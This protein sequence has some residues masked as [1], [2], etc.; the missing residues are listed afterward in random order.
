M[1]LPT[2]NQDISL[3]MYECVD[4]LTNIDRARDF[5]CPFAPRN[6]LKAQDE[7]R[8]KLVYSGYLKAID[9]ITKSVI[10]CNLKDKALCQNIL[11]LG[12]HIVDIT[13]SDYSIDSLATEE[14]QTI[15]Q[16]DSSRRLKDHPFHRK[17]HPSLTE[18]ELSDRCDE[19]MRWLS[20]NRIPAGRC[21]KDIVVAETVRI[22]PPYEHVTDYICP[23]RIILDRLK[24]IIEL[25]PKS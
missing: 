3:L 19:I 18:A 11:I 8:E 24:R 6:Y 16:N 5:D 15:I 4:V 1:A 23:T 7:G 21:G 12:R 22:K 14:V 13:K 20:K 10:L 17:E 25:R 2:N 9:P